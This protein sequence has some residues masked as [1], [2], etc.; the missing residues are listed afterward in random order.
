MDDLA[1]LCNLYG[2]GPATLE[3]LRREGC[4]SLASLRTWGAA[5]VAQSLDLPPA[6]AQRFLAEALVLEQR[7][8]LHA[9][10]P[11]QPPDSRAAGASAGVEAALAGSPAPADPPQAQRKASDPLLESALQA[12]RR[13]DAEDPPAALPF[14]PEPEESEEEVEDADQPALRSVTLE[15]PAPLANALRPKALDGLDHDLCAGL[16]ALGVY[17]LEEFCAARPLDLAQRLDVA[18]T[19]LMRLQFLARRLL[20]SRPED[21]ASTAARGPAS[22][23]PAM[24]GEA[25]GRSAGTPRM[26]VPG[27]SARLELAPEQV[28]GSAASERSGVVPSPA[29]AS[30]HAAG[31]S[32]CER[33]APQRFPPLLQEELGRPGPAAG[34]EPSGPFA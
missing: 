28:R 2:D 32:P 16:R 33:P 22:A 21:S 23:V 30:E 13:R 24:I 20:A 11:P 26:M 31:F 7:F 25:P 14:E 4:H 8:E 6:A 10:S 29:T 17:T 19:R 5:R 3:R 27:A 1:L 15:V 34:S 18:L 12:W 9:G